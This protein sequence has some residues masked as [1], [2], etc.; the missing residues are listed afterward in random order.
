[1]STVLSP[2]PPM[3]EPP[4]QL[5]ELT[6]PEP[7]TAST[8]IRQLLPTIEHYRREGRSVR[9]IHSAL[10]ANGHLSGCRWRTF[11]KTYYRVRKSASV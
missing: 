1:M 11:E 2:Q 10:V 3:E 5:I 6:F 7:V 4:P 8:Q 9:A